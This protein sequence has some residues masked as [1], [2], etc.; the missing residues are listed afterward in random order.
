MERLLGY[1]PDVR[2]RTKGIKKGV[3]R[4]VL[5][6]LIVLGGTGDI[7]TRGAVH[8][9]LGNVVKTAAGALAGLDEKDYNA[10]SA[11]RGQKLGEAMKQRDE[12]DQ[13]RKQQAVQDEAESE[14]LR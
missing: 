3:G 14:A 12:A 4:L 8:T 5:T 7:V 1:R 11:G 2:K 9:G 13:V 10:S 6:G